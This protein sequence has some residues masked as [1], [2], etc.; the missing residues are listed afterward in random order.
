MRFRRRGSARIIARNGRLRWTELAGVCAKEVPTR[1]RHHLSLGT[2]AI[3][4]VAVN[5]ALI[6]ATLL[7]AR[8]WRICAGAAGGVS[9][10]T[11][12]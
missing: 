3:E 6:E 10:D 12:Y 11:V 7:Q 4:T 8:I 2:D 9:V 5:R 1:I